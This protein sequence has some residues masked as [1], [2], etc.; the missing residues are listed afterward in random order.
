MIH[1]TAVVDSSVKLGT[2][3]SIGAYSVIGPHV[4]IGDDCTIGPHV[5]IQGPTRI[6][7]ETRIFQFASIGADPQDKK[8]HGENSEL[9]LGERNMIR[10]FVTINRGTADGGGATRIGDD[11]WIM[12]YCHIAHDCQVGSNTVFSNGA[13]LAGHCEVGDHVIFSGYSGAHQFCRIGRHAFLAMGTHLN[14]DLPPFMLAGVEYGR[15]RG[16]NSEGLKRRGFSP[17]RI[18]A[19][20]R[21]YKTIYTSGLTLEEARAE[22]SR[23]AV[24]APDVKE[25]LDFLNSGQRPLF[26]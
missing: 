6:G 8:F 14:G 2:G 25:M 13:T 10:E 1:P 20:K 15:P 11:N 22:L 19:I 4:D 21:A 24:N 12:A 9:I 16:I 7:R 17:E 5:V 18:A 3:V 23:A 26:R